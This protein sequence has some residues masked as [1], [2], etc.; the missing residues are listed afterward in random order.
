M[1]EKN[2]PRPIHRLR[3]V[4]YREYATFPTDCRKGDLAYATDHGIL[5]RWSGSGWQPITTIIPSGAI[6]MWSGT[7]AAI[8]AG[9]KLCDGTDGTPD[10]R[11]RFI[12]GNRGGIDPGTTGGA[13]A[14]TTA[15]HVHSQ[16]NHNHSVSIS[17]TT[18]ADATSGGNV[19][20][21]GLSVSGHTHSF[22]A[23]SITGDGGNQ[24]TGSKTD[25]ISD[26]RPPYY[27]LAFI[28]KT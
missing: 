25:S 15:G 21:G 26:I 11:E 9:Y 22:S 8:P 12:M 10:L 3:R 16:P 17:G 14:K 19:T 23:Y 5:Y 13:L 27:E 18:G 2:I 20:G 28:M 4:E 6:M 1:N 24:D 7:L